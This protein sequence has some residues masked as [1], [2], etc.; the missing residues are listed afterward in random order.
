M[1]SA[2]TFT[3]LTFTGTPNADDSLSARYVVDREKKG[4]T[5]F[6]PPGTSLPTDTG[7]NL[8]ASYITVL[9]AI[10]TSFH[11]DSIAGS[12]TSTGLQVG[13]FT[14]TQLDQISANLL[15]RLNAGEAATS[16]IADTAIL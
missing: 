11:S 12:K 5:A 2:I 10:V 3:S 14:Q 6:L 8:K 13:G 7:A 15:S 16:I 4:L 1:P 9:L